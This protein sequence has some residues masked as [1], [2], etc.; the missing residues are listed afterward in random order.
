MKEG[1]TINKSLTTLGM[2]ISALAD[3]SKKSGAGSGK[4]ADSHVP[5]RDSTLTFLL[6]ECLGG[7]AKTVMVAAISPADDNF[8]ESMSTL[9]Y[10]MP[11]I[12]VLLVFFFVFLFF[13]FWGGGSTTTD[14]GQ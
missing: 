13:F 10:K 8:D 7:N 14:G 12:Y 9:R 2:V 3:A 5:Y 1:S 4:K 6:K 11:Q